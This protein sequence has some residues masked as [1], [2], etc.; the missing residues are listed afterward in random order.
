MIMFLYG[1]DTYRSRQRLHQLKEAFVK[2]YDPTGTNTS[3]LDG[4][5]VGIEDIRR[6]IGTVGFLSSKRMVVIEDLIGKNKKLTLQQEVVEYIQPLSERDDT[7]I[8]FWEGDVGGSAVKKKPAKK[9][10]TVSRAKPLFTFLQSGEHVEDFPVLK[11]AELVLWM[12]KE[13]KSAGV[14]MNADAAEEL[15][16]SSNGDLWFMS[17]E[18]RKLA[19]YASGR[20][21]TLDDIR[22]MVRP[23]HDN[24]I[25]HLTDAL[26]ER[27]LSD[28]MRL[29]GEQLE[30]GA[31]ELYILTMLVRHFRLLMQIREMIENEP[32][33][34]TVS[35]RLKLHPFIAQRMIS[36]AK[37]FTVTELVGIY[38]ELIELDVQ[39]KTSWADPKVLLN[40]FAVRTCG[41]QAT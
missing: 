17:Q 40:L 15:I 34:A 28:A 4:S 39:F 13:A 1:P 10:P 27:Q 2:K 33:P 21:V 37:R 14:A 11:G 7:V 19:A 20:T 38:G 36:Q 30:S 12:R 29:I 24:N 5:K 32:N 9:K 25:F 23:A 18:I 3:T 41:G 22:A 31:H 6:A 26:A 35:T 8:I 16:A